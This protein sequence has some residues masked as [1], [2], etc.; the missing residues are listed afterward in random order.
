MEF[1]VEVFLVRR[2]VAD[3]SSAVLLAIVG[4][5]FGCMCFAMAERVCL[6]QGVVSLTVCLAAVLA[7]CLA[8][9][10]NFLGCV[11]GAL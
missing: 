10:S 11:G 9:V 6:R 2:T 8:V 4:C 1:L 7:S 5:A 3:K